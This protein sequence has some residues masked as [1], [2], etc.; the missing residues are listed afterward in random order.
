MGPAATQRLSAEISSIR[1][2][3]SMKKRPITELI[4]FLSGKMSMTRVYQPVIIKEL[5]S[6]EG[7]CSKAALAR[8]L[9]RRDRFLLDRYERILMR[10]PKLT[11]A[12]HGIV[13]YNRG[14]KRFEL[15]FEVSDAR[16]V[17]QAIGLCDQAIEAWE[18]AQDAL[19]G[20][21]AVLRK[22]RFQVLKEAQGKCMLCGISSRIVP[23]DV[24]HIVP[25]SSARE[26]VVVKDEKRIPVHAIENLQALCERCNRAK[27]DTDD[28][29]FSGR[30]KLVR[31]KIPQLIE[32]SGRRA[33]VE[34]LKGSRLEASLRDKLVE[35]HSEFI[36]DG[37]VEELVDIAEVVF[38]LAALRGISEA[39]FLGEVLA[40]R[41]SKGGFDDG[42]YLLGTE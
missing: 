27:R 10:W 22:D 28:T 13:S 16:G 25:Q 40:K 15:N 38:A 7:A 36:A 26:G 30:K 35:E 12:N 9:L 17:S 1:L 21:G 11:L 29:D 32:E 18:E 33:V 14:P 5:L 42:V 39:Q 24:D 4:A 41:E 3:G 23:L 2:I 19:P 31:D 37:S 34:R 20:R 8:A 6:Q